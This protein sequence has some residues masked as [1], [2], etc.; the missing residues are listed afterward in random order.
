MTRFAT[1]MLAGA[2]TLFTAAHTTPSFAQDHND[3]IRALTPKQPAAPAT[4]GFG[5][6]RSLKP[7]GNAA[8][9][10]AAPDP[11]T[12]AVVTRSLKRAILVKGTGGEPAEEKVEQATKQERQEIAE[13]VKEKPK[14]NLAIFFDYNSAEIAPQSLKTVGQLGLAL[15]SDALKDAIV[16]LNGHT[17]AAGSEE[18]NATLSHRRAESV[19]RYLIAN[20][21]IPPARLLVTGFGEEQ[22][23]NTADPLSGENRR[24]EVVNMTQTLAGQ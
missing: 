15:R 9:V 4:R 12:Q 22:L 10:A 8:P 2:V 19:R 11:R 16:M 3:I 5:T 18:Y 21:S 6:T 7:G 13:V 1:F 24:V 14:I 23:K 17:D 20:F